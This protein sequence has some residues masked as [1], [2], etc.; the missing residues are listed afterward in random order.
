VS[1]DCLRNRYGKGLVWTEAIAAL[2]NLVYD[3]LTK[4]DYDVF[5]SCLRQAMRWYTVVEGLGWGSLLLIPLEEVS[6]WWVERV[7]RVG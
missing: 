6:N 4:R 2:I 5:C 7:L 1:N 3:A